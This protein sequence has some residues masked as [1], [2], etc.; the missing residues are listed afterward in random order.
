MVTGQLF[1][2]AALAP[3]VVLVLHRLK[4]EGGTT[5]NGLREKISAIWEFTLAA[6]TSRFHNQEITAH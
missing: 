4:P 6:A 3:S 1:I 2:R 5:Q